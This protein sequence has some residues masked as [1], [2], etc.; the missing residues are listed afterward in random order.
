MNC[1]CGWGGDG[2]LGQ[3]WRT[4]TPLE[5][6]EKY[7]IEA[8]GYTRPNSKCPVCNASVFYYE[9][10]FGGRVFFESM[11]PPWPK[12]PCTDSTNQS[13]Q[14]KRS[15]GSVVGS[16]LGERV[17]PQ[18]QF[19]KW[20]PFI[21]DSVVSVKPYQI[22]FEIQG[23][24]QDQ[25]LTLFVAEKRLSPR[26]PFQIKKSR[27][28]EYNLSTLIWDESGVVAI[29]VVAF[30]NESDAQAYAS[31]N[32]KQPEPSTTPVAQK[33]IGQKTFPPDTS[34]KAVLHLTHAEP[35]TPKISS[36]VPSQTNQTP[37]A[38][39]S[40]ITETI[41]PAAQIARKNVSE[42][43]DRNEHAAANT[44]KKVSRRRK[45]LPPPNVPKPLPPVVFQPAMEIAFEKLL[46]IGSD[47][48]GE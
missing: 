23:Y 36:E 37:R 22:L 33:E 15:P 42:S 2:H 17:K 38:S 39:I 26:A 11:G 7:A 24:F 16:Q 10:P 14:T 29:E 43:K 18:W 30:T 25:R 46:G 3:R 40:S 9:S 5:L 1:R 13:K 8:R 48:V 45:D 41:R 31:T 21:C 34:K 44:Q 20:L 32:T 12:H 27:S 6:H 28:G 35:T 19:D 47:K 4:E